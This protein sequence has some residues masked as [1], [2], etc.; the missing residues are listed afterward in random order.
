MT[1]KNKDQYQ[2]VTAWSINHDEPN[3]YSYVPGKRTLTRIHSII[4]LPCN[5]Y[6]FYK[7]TIVQHHL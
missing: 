1:G 5:V 2:I 6:C 4:K 7:I 3:K